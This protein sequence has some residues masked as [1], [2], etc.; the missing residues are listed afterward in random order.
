MHGY[1]RYNRWTMKIGPFIKEIIA[2]VKMDYV[3]N[4]HIICV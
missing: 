3:Y 2:G 4:M 1:N